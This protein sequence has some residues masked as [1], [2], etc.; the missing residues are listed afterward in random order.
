VDGAISAVPANIFA[1]LPDARA[2]EVFTRLAATNG[3][4]VERIVSRG[5]VTPEDAP[6]RQD[7]DEW[8]LL[9]AGAA[10]LAIQGQDE[11]ALTPGDHVL[12]PGGAQHRVTWTAPETET[13]WV[14]VH[15][16]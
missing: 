9:V 15:F 6:W 2:G 3:A 12:I 4:V 16:G 10:R 13:V 8:V 1:D 7:H 11:V 5:Q 14:A